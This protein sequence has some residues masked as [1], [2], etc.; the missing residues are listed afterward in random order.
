MRSTIKG[1]TRR[2]LILAYIAQYA[3]EHGYTPSGREMAQALS[4]SSSSLLMFHLNRLELDGKISRYRETGPK[5]RASGRSIRIAGEVRGDKLAIAV[6]A[7]REIVA[8]HQQGGSVYQTSV[9]QIVKKALATIESEG[10]E[11]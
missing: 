8:V 10:G 1:D 11:T 4:I 5:R 2:T 9:R 3:G 6:E 7:L